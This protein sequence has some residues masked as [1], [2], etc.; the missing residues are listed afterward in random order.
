M[1]L[2]LYY[3]PWV[4][5]QRLILCIEADEKGIWKDFGVEIIGVDMMRSI[6]QK[7]VRSLELMLEIGYSNGTSSYSK[8]HS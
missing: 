2:M 5:K 3:P 8:L 7:I 4:V 6:L 1:I